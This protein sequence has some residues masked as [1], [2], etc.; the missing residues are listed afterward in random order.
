VNVY[1]P[2]TLTELWPLLDHPDTAIMAGGTD[3]LVRPRQAASSSADLCCL[4]RIR[5]LAGIHQDGDGL[6]IGALT[7]LTALLESRT[8]AATLP[9][10]HTAI[11]QLGSPLIRNQA[12]LGGNICT[13]SPA[14]DTLPPLYAL[15]A[16]LEIVAR[17]SRRMVAIDDFITGPGRTT[18]R[19]GEILAA[20]HIPRPAPGAVQHFEKVGRRR[21]LAI[22]VASLAAVIPLD[23][24]L[25]HDARLALGSV[26]PRVLRCR[27][28]EH[29]LRGHSL[30]LD[31][32]T[33]AAALIRQTVQPISDVRATAEYRR[34]VA[35]N[36]ILRLENFPVQ[37]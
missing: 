15:D 22:S 23:K 35:G 11:R 25:I 20:V 28:A 2:T 24:G 34:Q 13:A 37:G 3:L 17:D 14:G 12:T 5:E 9:L 8:V 29:F 19:P 16:R 6:R 7:T 21:A 33:Q 31:P 4:E 10:L 32:L 27:E 1:L 36:L 18:L 30:T 26:G